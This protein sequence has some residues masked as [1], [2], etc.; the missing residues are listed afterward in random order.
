MEMMDTLQTGLLLYKKVA[1][2]PVL[3][4]Y[5]FGYMYDCSSKQMTVKRTMVLGRGASTGGY[6]VHSC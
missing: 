3:S 2:I 5:I 6:T 1:Y 4:H